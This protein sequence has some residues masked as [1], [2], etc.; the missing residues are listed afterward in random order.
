M[1]M[2]DPNEPAKPYNAPGGQGNV[3]PPVPAYNAPTVPPGSWP[4][5]GVPNASP[6][7][8]F[9]PPAAGYGQSPPYAPSD[10]YVP[11][12]APPPPGVWPPP[13]GYYPQPQAGY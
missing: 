5:S 6:P 1:T 12:S 10:G 3:V 13:P 4:Q 2:P 7:P 11:G 8:G 9:P